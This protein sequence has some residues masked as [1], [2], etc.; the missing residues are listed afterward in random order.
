VIWQPKGKLRKIECSLDSNPGQEC[1]VITNS[2]AANK[3]IIIN[4]TFFEGRPT[5]TTAT[6]TTTTTIT[7]SM[8]RK[9]KSLFVSF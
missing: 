6:A 8:T 3:N 1:E 4:D 2:R 9:R 5:N 7:S